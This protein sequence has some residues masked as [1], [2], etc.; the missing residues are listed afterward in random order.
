M[1][2]SSD[3]VV[4]GESGQAKARVAE[5]G[6]NFDTTETAIQEEVRQPVWM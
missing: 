2:S 3:A 6:G 1:S 5:R 4:L